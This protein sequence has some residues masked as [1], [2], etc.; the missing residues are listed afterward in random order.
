MKGEVC[1]NE[2]PASFLVR[3]QVM[4]RWQYLSDQSTNQG[5]TES[6]CSSPFLCTH[7]PRPSDEHAYQVLHW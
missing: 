6:S 2:Q 1:P 7:K 4:Y 3:N 5:V